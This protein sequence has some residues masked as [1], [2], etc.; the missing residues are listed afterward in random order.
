LLPRRKSPEV[1]EMLPLTHFV[2]ESGGGE[3]LIVA[4]LSPARRFS[5]GIDVRDEVEPRFD[6]SQEQ[7]GEERQ[8]DGEITQARG[9]LVER[10][11]PAV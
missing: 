3:D 6:E 7:K 2:P 8:R 5:A 9:D 11:R 1:G 10:E 4:G